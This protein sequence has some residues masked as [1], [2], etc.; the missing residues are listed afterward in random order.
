MSFGARPAD[1]FRQ[2]LRHGLMLAAAGIGVGVTAAFALTRALGGLLVNVTPT[3]PA[4]YV[5]IAAFFLV[6]AL[7][8]SSIPALAAA[9]VHPMTV[10][11]DE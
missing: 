6:I 5:T 4:T 1:I 10:L 11:R 9:R 8:A 3:D 7:I 2:F